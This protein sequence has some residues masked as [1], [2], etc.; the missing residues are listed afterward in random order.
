MVFFQRFL[1]TFL[2]KPY[3]F[4]DTTSVELFTDDDYTSMSNN[5]YDLCATL[6]INMKAVG[7]GFHLYKLD[8]F[9]IST[10]SVESLR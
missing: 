8:C 10:P 7:E 5:V 3:L 1:D 6:K 2:V 9:P 4:M